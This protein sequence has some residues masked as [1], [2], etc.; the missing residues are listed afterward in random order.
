MTIS[1][2]KF[3]TL[4]SAF[5][6]LTIVYLSF[7]DKGSSVFWAIYSFG[8]KDVLIILLS[9]LFFGQHKISDLFAIGLSC[10]L[11][12]PTIIRISCAIKAKFNYLTYRELLKNSE[13]SYFLLLILFFISIVIYYEFRN[14]RKN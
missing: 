2:K 7:P 9:L 14:E 8:I 1:V 12:V 13:Y 5:A 3:I 11:S 4:V 10:Y 6:V